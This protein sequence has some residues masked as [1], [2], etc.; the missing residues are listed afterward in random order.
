MKNHWLES[1]SKLN[2]TKE[3]AVI[4]TLIRSEGSVPQEL[5]AKAIV[6]QKGLY[7][8]SVGGGRV[9][10]K[11]IDFAREMLSQYTLG[12]GDRLSRTQVFEWNLVK[13]VGM[14]CGGTITFLFELFANP[15]W[16]IVVFGAG[17]VSQE[18]VPLLCRLDCQVTCID[19][20]SE[21][22][23]RIEDRGNLKKIFTANAIELLPQFPE[24]TFFVSITQGHRTDLPIL[25]EILQTRRPP[26]VGVIG[27]ASK[28]LV[29]RKD[30]AKLGIAAEQLAAFHC[31]IGLPVGNSNPAEIAISIAAQLLAVRDQ[32]SR[33]QSTEDRIGST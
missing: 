17:H 32:R 4:V 10:A 6:S 12:S 15:S 9:E 26:Y 28:A 3:P 11:A 23:D 21:W 5:G 14:T 7:S 25:H 18:L 1:L 16:N 33:D 8:G 30:L 27:S 24:E 29:L 20:R 2:A 13:D 31:P 19:D 22:L